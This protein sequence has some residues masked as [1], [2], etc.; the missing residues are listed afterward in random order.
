M[1]SPCHLTIFIPPTEFL[2]AGMVK[3]EEYSNMEMYM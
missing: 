3:P 1:R 2:K